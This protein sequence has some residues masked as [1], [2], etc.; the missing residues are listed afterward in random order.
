MVCPSAPLRCRSLWVGLVGVLGLG[1]TACDPPARTL[2]PTTAS[3]TLRPDC[4]DNACV[5]VFVDDAP[6]GYLAA[7]DLTRDVPLSRVLPSSTPAPDAWTRLA[8]L[9]AGGQSFSRSKPVEAL[10]GAL[11]VVA[12]DSAGGVALYFQR[13]ADAPPTSRVVGIQ[14]LRISTVFVPEVLVVDASIR[15]QLSDGSHQAVPDTALDG[16]V[17]VPDPERP[18][19]TPHWLKLDDLDAL[20]DGGPGP[21][22]IHGADGQSVVVSAADRRQSTVLFK[23]NKK[24]NVVV[25]GWRTTEGETVRFVDVEEVERLAFGR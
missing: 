8:G 10:D 2:K 25:R 22:T 12:P 17:R 24:G 5:G 1:S 9:A 14:T 23:R 21:V 15:V 4:P 16:L 13:G 11:P 18:E 19:K 6:I 3:P 7:A 20:V